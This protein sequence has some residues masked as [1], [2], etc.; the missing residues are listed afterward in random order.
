MVPF[1]AG[2]EGPLSSLA[3]A[4]PAAAQIAVLWWAMLAGAVLITLMVLALVWRGFAAPPHPRPGE[5]FWIHGMGLGFSLAVLAAV[6]GAGIWVGERLQARPDPEAIRVEAIARQWDWRFRQPGPDGRMVETRGQ[7][8]IPA[9][10]PVDVVIRSEDVIHSFWV[11][12]LAGKMDA[13]PGRDNLLRIQADAPGLYHGT[14][15]EFSGTGY[16]GMRFEVL[17]WPPDDPPDLTAEES[18]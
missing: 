3:P 4:G 16:A 6:V 10:R 5:S 2:C 7:L 12:R 8:H 15:A 18:E 14:S 11:P 9:G 17:V 1:L 13:L